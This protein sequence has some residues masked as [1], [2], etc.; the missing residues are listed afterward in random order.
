MNKTPKIGYVRASFLKASR[1]SSRPLLCLMI[2]VLAFAAACSPSM[3][4]SWISNAGMNLPECVI[5][6]NGQSEKDPD[7]E[8]YKNV[9]NSVALHWEVLSAE[10][11]PGLKP[12]GSRLILILPART[13]RSLTAVQIQSAES[14]VKK[15]ALLI[16][17]GITPLTEKLGFH[18]GKTIPVQHLQETAFPD[19]EIS[20]DKEIP[21]TSLRV[22]SHAMVL[23]RERT[24]GEPMVSLLSYGRG[25]CLLFALELDSDKGDGYARFPYFHQ[26]LR[27]AGIQFPFRSERLSALF[28]YAYR[29]DQ[30][31]DVLAKYW[32]QTGIQALHVGAWYYFDEDKE[33]ETYLEQLIHACHRNGILVYAWL[34]L[35]H[36][37]Q[38]FWDKH[39]QWREKTATGRDAHVDWRLLM[40]LKDPECFKAIEKSLEQLL[41]R[42]EWDGVNLAEIYFDGTSGA[43][44]PDDFTPMNSFVRSE[45]QR[46]YGIDPLDYFRPESALYWKRAPLEWKKFVEYRIKLET[47]LNERF[48]QVFSQFRRSIRPSLDVTVTY[49]DNIYDPS[50]REAVGADVTEMFGLMDKYD[51]TLVLED[52][53]TVWHLGPRRYAQLAGTYAKLTRN[54]H[55]LGIDINIVDREKAFP[56][57]KQTGSE[58]LQLF[59]FAGEN[60]NTVMAYSE[61]TLLGQD[62]ELL[63]SALVNGARG[64]LEESGVQIEAARPVVYR[65]GLKLAGFRVDGKPW[66][67]SDGGDVGL[68]AGS[69]SVSADSEY[70]PCPKLV[71]LN[72]DILHA[73][74]TAKN[75]INFNYH[76]G[77]QAIAVFSQI[78]KSVM[79]DGKLLVNSRSEWVMLP[80][81]S[82]QIQAAF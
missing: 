68:P 45:F 71:R 6:E 48:L 17:E 63:A 66:P 28:D 14:L 39:P 73:E 78:P 46:Q 40:N 82:H 75:I 12:S 18:S 21:V 47:N 53:W 37:S 51:F 79:L 44:D 81:G 58:F 50:M 59:Y 26:E 34:E 38:G 10:R 1:L 9:L 55:R 56:T 8:A 11:L 33:A 13:A 42:F 52:P 29:V 61:Q 41:R 15:G 20:W 49:V 5:V 27:R 7:I 22:P 65:S 74:Y 43:E 25:G 64:K 2:V 57:L 23:N 32:R 35:P 62:A 3:N 72:G 60:F 31:P 36:V 4:K 69:H 19:I 54:T 30:N 70:A 16:S 67:Y 24:S 76:A 80:A 77:R